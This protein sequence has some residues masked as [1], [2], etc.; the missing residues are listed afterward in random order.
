MSRRN[1]ELLLLCVAAPIVIVLFAM[2][3]VTG[4]QAISFNTLGVPIGIFAAFLIAH[5]AIRKLAP[6]SDPALLPITFALSGIGIAFVTRLAPNAAPRQLIW[7]FAG[8]AMLVL[9]LLLV[10]NID[11]LSS[12]KYTLMIVGVL[13][14]LSPMLPGIGQEINGSRLWLSLAGFSVQPGEIAKICIV[15]FLAA[16]LAQNREMLSVFTWKV[17]PL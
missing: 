1:L 14:L 5:F 9:V 2:L 12:Y 15:L 17:G 7:M 13:L 3:V 4:G 11:R 8:V 16:Y 10:R 6:N